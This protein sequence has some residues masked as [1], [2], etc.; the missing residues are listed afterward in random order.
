MPRYYKQRTRSDPVSS[1][2]ES[3]KRGLE[4][5]VRRIVIVGDVTRKL[6]VTD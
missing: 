4:P 2:R 6:L 3:V 5:G 1:V